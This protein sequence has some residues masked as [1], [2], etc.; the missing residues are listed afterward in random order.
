VSAELT[1]AIDDARYILGEALPAYEQGKLTGVE[2]LY[3]LTT[4]YRSIGVAEL[5]LRGVPDLLFVRQMQ[6]ASIFAFGLPG[7]TDDDK[8]TA[9]AAPFWDAVSATYWDAARQIALASRMSH[10]PKREHEDDFLYVAFLMQRYFLAPEPDASDDERAAHE[11]AQVQ[12]LERWGEVL[13]GALD[14][15]LPLCHAL[16]D[17]DTEAF[18]EA[19][20]AMSDAR[21]EDLSARGKR[22][23]LSKEELA[24]LRP[25]WPQGLALLRLAERE[26]LVLEDGLEVPGVPPV[27]RVDVPYIYQADA[28]RSIDY[29]PRRLVL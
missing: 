4:M 16:L 14:P 3:G 21:T 11:E 26:G 5:L 12:R 17:Q 7:L 10:N 27:I 13:E 6:S 20:L 24:W 1:T 8:T 25:I 19:L 29:Q 23:R 18:A 22:G 9:L 2:E 15:R 28:W